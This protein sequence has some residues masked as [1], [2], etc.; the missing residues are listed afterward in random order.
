[1]RLGGIWVSSGRH[2]GGLDS[3][4]VPRGIWSIWA[5]KSDAT[6]EPF[7]FFG[8]SGSKT[9]I[10][11]ESGEGEVH[12]DCENTCN[13]RRNPP[14][15][16]WQSSTGSLSNPPE[17]LQLEAVWGICCELHM[18]SHVHISQAFKKHKKQ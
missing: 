2:L 4:G 5:H 18:D 11:C 15:R 16:E 13:L 9:Q 8:D 14:P 10:L 3:Q 12:F 6:L 17:P 7:A 1:M